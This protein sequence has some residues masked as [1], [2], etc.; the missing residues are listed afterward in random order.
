[1][2]TIALPMMI[3][4]F[5]T[6]LVSLA[7]TG[8]VG[9]LRDEVLI[10]GVAL[11]AVIFDVLFTTFNFLRGATTGFTAQAVGADD[12][13]AEQRMLLGGILIAIGAGLLI[14]LLHVPIGHLGLLVLGADGEVGE[15][16]WTYYSW[17]VWSAPF[18]LFN[19]VVFGWVIGRGEAVTALSLQVA[20][21]ALN[22]FFSFYGCCG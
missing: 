20:L 7:A 19:F 11:A 4:H 22:L 8:V 3:A 15:A 18:A 5:S 21:N 1:M 14:L 9:Q 17:R 2:L 16:A 10:G 12:R 6:P 13:R